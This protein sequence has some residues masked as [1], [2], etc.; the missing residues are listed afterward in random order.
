MLD[1]LDKRIIAVMQG[2]FPLV[3][4]PYKELAEKIG[5]SEQQLLEKLNEYRMTGKLRKMGVVLRHRE[6]GYAANA[7]CA[8]KVPA[9]RLKEVG[10]LM[11]GY[12]IVTHCYS[13]VPQPHWPY[14]FYTM[15]H[16][17]TREECRDLADKLANLA[18]LDNY[19]L[20][21]STREWK[22]SSMIYFPEFSKGE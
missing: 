7:L 18:G 8:W 21:F 11:S 20:L 14:N 15:L 19:Q 22:K 1:N 13:R 4:E 10:E 3:A 17:H 12:K 2:E 5:I 16:A 9:A 6:V